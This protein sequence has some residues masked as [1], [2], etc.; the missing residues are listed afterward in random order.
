MRRIC[1]LLIILSLSSSLMAQRTALPSARKRAVY[2]NHYYV[3]P[4]RYDY[5]GIAR[6]ITSGMDSRYDK[7]RAL[8]LWICSHIRYDRTMTFRTAD[9]CWDNGKAV[10]QGICELYYRMCEC[11]KLKSQLIFGMAKHPR[12]STPEQHT[13]LR[14]KTEKGWILLDPTWG[15]S[16]S[17]HNQWTH[18]PDP[19]IWFDVDAQEFS[20]T[21]EANNEKNNNFAMPIQE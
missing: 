1:I 18:L 16:L 12:S 10:C 19:I 21:H 17:F 11:L 20:K 9:D 8:Y 4:S 15:T 13:W 6:D 7:A 5:R 3:S 14:V 2:G